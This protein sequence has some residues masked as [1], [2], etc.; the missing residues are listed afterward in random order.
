MAYLQ[1]ISIKGFRSIKEADIELG[2]LNVLIGANGSGK[3]NFVSFFD[4]LSE[5]MLG[6]LKN[7][8]SA[9]G[10]A[11]SFLYLGPE[12]TP[13][14]TAVLEFASEDVI[15]TYQMRMSYAARDSLVISDETLTREHK[16]LAI[17]KQTIVLPGS[18][19][20]ARIAELSSDGP[21]EA[22]HVAK[23][24]N[25]CW[26]YHFQNMSPS[27][28]IRQHSYIGENRW[29]LRD[30][31]NLAALLYVYR[32]KY[33]MVY[34][35]IVS[36]IRKVLP[37]FGDFDLNPHQ[38]NAKEIDLEWRKSGADYLFGP[39]Q[40][41]DGSLRAM[42]ILTLLLQP[43]KELPGVIILDEPELG[44]HPYA[45]AIIAGLLRAASLSS[46]VIVATQSQAFLDHFEP[47]EILVVDAD[48]NGSHFKRLDEEELK[49][50]LAD[51][52]I[53]ELWDKNVIGGGPFS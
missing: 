2:K 20:E 13:E 37:G 7:Y 40:I 47:S 32:Q 26:V 6:R 15:D 1:R 27:A 31:G 19:L 43:E 23:F 44:L 10:F 29:L 28:R 4:M 12:I 5:M 14:M 36:A 3:S 21:P 42:A 48:K 33:E 49:D 41:S 8:V 16:R 25:D 11:K 45:V 17:P 9:T 39:H 22:M 51:Y 46:Q 52:S 38:L 18:G 34:R 24:L 50:W 53:G 30:G 35:R